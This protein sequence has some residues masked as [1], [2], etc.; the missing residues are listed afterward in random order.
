MGKLI[1]FNKCRN[2][3]RGNNIKINKENKL[4]I[5]KELLEM[6]DNTEEKTID[7]VGTIHYVRKNTPLPYLLFVPNEIDENKRLMVEANNC[8]SDN[9]EDVIRQAV[10]PIKTLG[11]ASEFK[12]PI[13]VPIIP[14]E[15]NKPYYQQLSRDM[16]YEKDLMHIEEKYNDTITNALNR[17][18]QKTNKKIDNKVFMNGYSSS[19]VFAQRFALFHPERIDTMCV[20]GASGSVP[21]PTTSVP[22]PLGIGG[23]TDFDQNSYNNIK[24]RYYVGEYET[25]RMSRRDDEHP[26]WYRKDMVDGKEVIIDA[27]MHDMTYF[28]RSIP[29]DVGKLYRDRYGKDYFERVYHVTDLYKKL[30]YDFESTIIKRRAHTTM[31]Y[32]GK[33]YEGVHDKSIPIIEKAYQESIIL[34]EDQNKK[35]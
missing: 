25:V 28:P 5:V 22:Y 33:H 12:A 4:D 7:G 34:K 18:E 17:I 14:S 8:E 20:G 16:F 2:I 26:E 35:I 19:A 32:E 31:D 6:D 23:L 10:D 11:Q 15:K 30:G 9:Y 13:L 3:L 21:V 29:T 27:P 1:L 24:F